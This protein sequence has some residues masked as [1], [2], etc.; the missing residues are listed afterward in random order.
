MYKLLWYGILGVILLVSFLLIVKPNER[1]QK[2]PYYFQANTRQKK[3]NEKAL[4]CKEFPSVPLPTY[5]ITSNYFNDF[6]NS[7][8]QFSQF[9]FRYTISPVSQKSNSWE[10]VFII[11]SPTDLDPNTDLL[12]NKTLN[13]INSYSANYDINSTSESYM[14]DIGSALIMP[15]LQIIQ[16]QSS[17]YF[18]SEEYNGREYRRIIVEE[19]FG[20]ENYISMTI[21]GPQLEPFTRPVSKTFCKGWDPGDSPPSE[22]M[23]LINYI[24][25]TIFPY[26]RGQGVP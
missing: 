9:R 10:Y 20:H 17:Y 12:V 26:M 23:P 21:E 1:G 5:P 11:Q 22:L 16:S 6:M 19:D 24:E 7:T 8:E 2:P 15:M 18:N 4:I 13:T 14:L 25:N 3:S